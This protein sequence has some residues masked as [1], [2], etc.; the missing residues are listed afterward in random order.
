MGHHLPS[1]P[2]V[3]AP[4]PLYPTRLV[5]TSTVR[6]GMQCS[7]RHCRT[8]RWLCDVAASCG[9]INV[10]GVPTLPWNQ[11]IGAA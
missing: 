3:V 10:L 5:H 9:R 7:R 6:C 2:A 1:P 4:L 11:K 8:T